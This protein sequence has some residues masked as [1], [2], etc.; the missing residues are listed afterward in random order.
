MNPFVFFTLFLALLI[1]SK[2]CLVISTTLVENAQYGSGYSDEAF[3][4]SMTG[5]VRN[6]QDVKAAMSHY[7][8]N[9]GEGTVSF[10]IGLAPNYVPTTP[11]T[12]YLDY[13]W[14]D[15]EE[16]EVKEW[17]GFSER[18]LYFGYNAGTSSGGWGVMACDNCSSKLYYEEACN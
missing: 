12:M 6:S 18:H 5:L 14:Y 1:G 13:D 10:E 4:S 17:D 2:G 8:L 9:E 7:S 15:I 11:Y 3:T 16:D